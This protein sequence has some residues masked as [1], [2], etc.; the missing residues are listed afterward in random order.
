MD[1][2]RA[3]CPDALAPGLPNAYVVPVI[4][5]DAHKSDLHVAYN[6]TDATCL[7]GNYAL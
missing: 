2:A 3:A 6:L 1:R 4:P 5:E 7:N